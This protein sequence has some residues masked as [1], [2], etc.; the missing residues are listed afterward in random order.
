MIRNLVKFSR[1]KVLETL[2]GNRRQAFSAV[3][4]EPRDDLHGP[5][6]AADGERR[7]EA[8]G[9]CPPRHHLDRGHPPPA[10]EPAAARYLAPD[11]TPG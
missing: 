11:V 10:A 8:A 2:A 6:V 5:T 4:L 9:R 7:E 3:G 1:F